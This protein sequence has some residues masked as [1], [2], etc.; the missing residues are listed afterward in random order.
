MISALQNKKTRFIFS[1]SNAVFSGTH[2]PY[3]ERDIPHPLNFYG[4][5][6]LRA[7][8]A[9][10]KSR[11][12]STIIRF[13]TIY[14][15]PPLGARANDLNYYLEKLKENQRLHLVNDLFFNPISAFEAA[16]TVKKVLTDQKRGIWHVAGKDQV[17]RY[18]L[19]KMI[20]Q[21]FGIQNPQLVPVSHTYFSNSAK[22]PLR[23]ILSIH[24]L[25]RTLKFSPLSIT[26][27]L[28]LFKRHSR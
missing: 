9:V 17:S 8:I 28:S 15:W 14:G 24:K 10:K 11:L 3:R 21:V 12:P 1:S 26:N 18:T 27:A 19:V 13:T 23:A 7:E 6:K 20:A 25:E 5:T 4:T 2:P 16:N 22:R